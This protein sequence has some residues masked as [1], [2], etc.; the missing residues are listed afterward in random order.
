MLTYIYTLSDPRTN[1][2]R[3]VGKTVNP[4]QRK[5]N[6]SNIARDKNTHKRNWINQ[7]KKEGIKPVFEIIDEVTEDWKFWER[8]WIQQFKIW[9]FSLTNT[10]LG[11]EGLETGNQT[12]FKKGLI[13]WNKGK[14]ATKICFIC[15]NK[16]ASCSSAKKA[17][18][19]K[20]CEKEYRKN[21][22][23]ST[24]FKPG[25]VPW[26]KGKPGYSTSRKGQKV[27]EVEKERLQKL[28][29]G[30][31]YRSKQVKQY[32]KNMELLNTFESITQAKKL[33]GI[34]S[35][36]NAVIGRSK[37]AGGFIWQL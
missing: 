20:I 24:T 23:S 5:H 33:T 26:N 6:H 29:I 22:Q 15:K 37:T 12:S 34:N 17:T 11:G 8:Y 36:G 9:G 25:I 35:I 19:S 10:T 30:N 18:C 14:G 32:T 7:L 27:S 16:F 31:T 21:R 28:A 1:Q 4:K 3:Y 2:V 13:P